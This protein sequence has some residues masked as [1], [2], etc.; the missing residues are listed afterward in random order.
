MNLIIFS[1]KYF[2]DKFQI[3]IALYEIKADIYE[4]LWMM[5]TDQSMFVNKTKM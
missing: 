2:S 3:V 1:E 4:E 5:H